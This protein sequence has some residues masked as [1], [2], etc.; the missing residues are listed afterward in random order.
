VLL[1][2]PR[3]KAPRLVTRY[4]SAGIASP[5][6]VAA[7]F[8]NE[9]SE[10]CRQVLDR[11]SDYLDG[12][13]APEAAAEVQRHLQMCISCLAFAQALRRTIDRCR[14]YR[15]EARPRPLSPS[16]RAQLLRAWQTALAGRRN[17][18]RQCGEGYCAEDT[19]R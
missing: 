12:E 3:C 1:H 16:S 18:N 7:E 14:H 4:S 2:P 10:V 5:G 17:S 15:P 13:L 9:P 8:M 11:L 6:G 19:T